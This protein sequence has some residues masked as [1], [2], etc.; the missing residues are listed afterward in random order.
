MKLTVESTSK[1]V[2]LNGVLARVWEGQ[3]ESGIKIHYGENLDAV[4][5]IKQL[6]DEY[7]FSVQFELQFMEE[8]CVSYEKKSGYKDND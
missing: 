3:T 5:Q 7:N 1:I 6:R 2:E 8:R 4:R